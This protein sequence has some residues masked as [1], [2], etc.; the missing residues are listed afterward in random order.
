MPPENALSASA[1]FSAPVDIFQRGCIKVNKKMC[2]KLRCYIGPGFSLPC[3]R[4]QR[5]KP[6]ETMRDKNASFQVV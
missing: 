2:G 1:K 3:K 5:K 6:L 4:A